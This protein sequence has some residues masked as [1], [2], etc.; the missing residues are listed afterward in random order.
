Y[1]L[2]SG[3]QCQNICEYSTVSLPYVRQKKDGSLLLTKRTVD[4]F[5]AE[6]EAAQL[7]QQLRQQTKKLALQRNKKQQ[8]QVSFD[9][10]AFFR[11]L[12]APNF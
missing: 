6:K 12:F 2:P 7:A 9:I 11:F 10:R 5:R 1:L 4:L 3:E 8:H